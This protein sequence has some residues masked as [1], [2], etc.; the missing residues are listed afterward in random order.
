MAKVMI[1][2]PDEL[3]ARVDAEAERS[4]RSRSAVLREYAREALDERSA[5][6]A[7][8]MRDLNRGARGHGGEVV[9]ELKA[10]RPS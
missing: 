6:L 10:G 3:L 2:L 8:R 7:G 4:G 9:G 1:S 5:R